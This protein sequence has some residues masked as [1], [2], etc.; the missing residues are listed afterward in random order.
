VSSQPRYSLDAYLLHL[1]ST[2][3]AAQRSLGEAQSRHHEEQQKLADLL[4]ARDATQAELR[5]RQDALQSGLRTAQWKVADIVSRENHL[6]RLRA[7]LDGQRRAILT[8]RHAVH[9]AESA[10]EE[11]R[12]KLEEIAGETKA[13][14][15]RKEAWLEELRRE[16]QRAEQRRTE[17]IGQMIHERRRRE[18]R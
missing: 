17:E 15:G 12:H 10:V 6:R 1:R 14:E 3:D 13:H 8:Q 2:L 7:D 4:R 11:A 5:R 18:E 9:K 16:Q